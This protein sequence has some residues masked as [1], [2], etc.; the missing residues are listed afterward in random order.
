MSPTL[1]LAMPAK[2]VTLVLLPGLDG[3]GILFEPL[4]AAIAALNAQQIAIAPH[5]LCY[6][7]LCAWGYEAWIDSVHAQLASLVQSGEPFILLGE[8][9]SGPIAI[10]LAARHPANLLGV[11]LCATFAHQPHPLLTASKPVINWFPLPRNTAKNPAGTYALLGYN[12]TADLRALAFRALSP[13]PPATVRARLKAVATVDKRAEL[14]AIRVPMLYLQAKR[15]RLV[16]AS[17]TR[18]M[19]ALKPEMQCELFDTA[20]GLLQ[21]APSA[22]AQSIQRFAQAIA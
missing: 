22:A 7:P 9:F 1:P 18:A 19:Q 20:H 5:V 3:S 4:V 15:D 11:V 10:S 17:A 13:L 16:L 14:Q 12:T 8:S 2:P 6:D 21:I